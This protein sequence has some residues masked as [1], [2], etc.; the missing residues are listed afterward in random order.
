M[1]PGIYRVED[2][3]SD[4]QWGTTEAANENMTTG[5]K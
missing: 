4:A 3:L 5:T 1:T 2:E